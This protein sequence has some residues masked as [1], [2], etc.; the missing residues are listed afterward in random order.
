VVA[1]LPLISRSPLKEVM[2][3]K[4]TQPEFRKPKLSLKKEALRSLNDNLLDAVVGGY[5]DGSETRPITAGTATNPN[6][7]QVD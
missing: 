5:D 7:H 2:T 3:D 1:P 6:T 4:R